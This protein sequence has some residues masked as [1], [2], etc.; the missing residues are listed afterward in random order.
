[1]K[2]LEVFLETI[3]KIQL[4]DFI[5][6]KRYVENLQ[7]EVRVRTTCCFSYL[8]DG[9][10]KRCKTCPQTCSVKRRE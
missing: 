3:M 8:L 2:H 6:N 7:A 5:H 10:P 9:A 1:M 4:K